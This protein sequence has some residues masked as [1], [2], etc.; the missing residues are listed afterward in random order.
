[1]RQ[2]GKGQRLGVFCPND[3]MV[4]I[5]AIIDRK[6][7]NQTASMNMTPARFYLPFVSLYLFEFLF[8]F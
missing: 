8:S 4:G 7:V 2:L 3:I 1:M 5:R 6:S